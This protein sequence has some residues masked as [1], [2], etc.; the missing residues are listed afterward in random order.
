MT[1]LRPALSLFSFFTLLT[2]LA[3]PLGI[4]AVAQ[5]AFPHQANGSPVTRDDVVVGSA[6]IGQSFAEPGYFW[7]RPSATSSHPYDATASAGS[8]FGPTNPALLGRV[9][10]EVTRFASGGAETEVPV[11]LVTTSGSGLDPHVSPAGAL[12]QVERVAAARGVSSEAVRALVRE[13]V[14]PSTLSLFGAP[15]VNVL[16]LNLALDDRFGRPAS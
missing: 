8:N 10:G 6:L 11:D 3:Y 2:G 5:L 15:R 4:T 13:H 12:Y 7:S 1:M 16:L 14:E 9:E